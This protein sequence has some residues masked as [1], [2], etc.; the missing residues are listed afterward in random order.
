MADVEQ[1]VKRLLEVYPHPK[2]AL[3]Y[4]NPLELLVATILSAQ[5]TDARVN[6]VTRALF[7]KYRTAEDYARADL[8]TLEQEIRPTGYYRT[9]ARTLIRCCQALVER[10]GGQVPD[11]LEDLV[12]LPGV[13]RKTA[14]FV[15]G[16]A[17]GRP[18]IP[19]DTH[20]LRVANRLGLAHSRNAD[21]VEQS[22]MA[23]VPQ[24]YWTPF[25][26]AMILHGRSVCTA[27]HPQCE[28]CVLLD[29]CEWPDKPVSAPSPGAE[30]AR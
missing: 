10:F 28:S 4:S 17:F 30:R 14:N 20:V 22:L 27:R 3:E 21:K 1:I 15:L 9:K 18:A 12:S 26:L 11:K 2:V 25:S 8:E 19:V 16:S 5:C 7:Q 23:Q 13:G 29:L 24:R 6:Q